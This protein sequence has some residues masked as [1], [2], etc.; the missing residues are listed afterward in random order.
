MKKRLR[1]VS[2]IHDNRKFAKRVFY[3]ITG[4]L[5]AV[6]LTGCAAKDA[7]MDAVS[8]GMKESAN[9]AVAGTDGA[10][11]LY[12][13]TASESVAANGSAVRDDMAYGEAEMQTEEYSAIEE[14]GFTQVKVQPL[15]TFSA[16]VDTASYSNIRR[17]LFQGTAAEDIPEGAVR[18][19]EMLNYFSYDYEEPK[20]GE[21]FGI[22][23]DGAVCPWQE[24][25]GLIRIGIKTE[26]IDFSETPKSNLVFLLDVSGSMDEPNKLPLLKQAF[27]MLVD[28]LGEKDRVSIV[29]YAGSDAV[30]LDGA[31]GD[32]KG[33]ILEALNYLEAGG[34]TNGS[35]GI[36]TA[37]A[38]A[39]KYLIEGGNNRVILATDGDLN[40]GQTSE[41]E[42]KSI[43]KEKKKSGV[44]LS[45]LG[46]GEG[47]LK[48]NKLETL[49]DSGNGNYAYIDSLME[50]KRVLVD[51]LGST[52]VTVAEDV[53]FQVEFNPEQIAEYRLL[54]YENRML[55]AED[56]T[57]DT[58]DA[59]EVGAGHTVTVLYEVVWAGQGEDNGIELKYQNVEPAEGEVMKEWATL[60][61]RYKEPGKSKSTELE[62]AFGAD[63]YK[64]NVKD[65]G[66]LL[67]ASVAEFGL[68]LRDSKWKG[69]ASYE[70]I[71][72]MWEDLLYGGNEEVAE[73]I[74]L[75]QIASGKSGICI[76]LPDDKEGNDSEGEV[77]LPIE[78]E[79][80]KGKVALRVEAES[81]GAAD[82]TFY[83]ENTTD[84]T[85]YYGDDYTIQ[86]KEGK[87]WISLKTKDGIG[88][89][90][91]AYILEP[92][93]EQSL[94]LSWE[95]AY[96][97]LS[98]GT[99]RLQK[100]VYCETDRSADETVS[101][102]F[103]VVEGL[104]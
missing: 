84:R 51:E 21:P 62:Q 17:M 1:I 68:L 61:I 67:E 44:Y 89:N 11:Y 38:I 64:E 2:F 20:S 93:T 32:E 5:L 33:K 26:D 91:L 52:L 82:G 6:S 85:Y 23:I 42:L 56:F 98:A 9:M 29:T 80:G 55:S 63:I 96:G 69:Q 35:A 75:V 86:K 92:G 36:E 25:H 45:V 72:G 83:I 43:V 10:S 74:Q 77:T 99:Y 16:D 7:V 70:H 66:M 73:F 3:C 81:V 100:E 57:D 8:G 87:N 50:A 12:E 34:G 37:Y 79:S 59:G 71:L 19:E 97:T 58:K 22:T 13:E 104:R 88:W 40:I 103:E 49:A 54:G 24:E 95:W 60:K 46:F 78:E 53:K 48:D 47:N 27:A 76:E 65:A 14:N 94:E 39:E 30:V 31:R 41:S 18:I 102:E 28:N 101:V 4:V 90:D 15:S